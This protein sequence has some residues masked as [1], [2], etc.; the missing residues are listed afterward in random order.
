MRALRLVLITIVLSLLLAPVAQAAPVGCAQAAP[1]PD[2][3]QR[4]HGHHPR[5]GREPLVHRELGE[6]APPRSAASRRPA[7]SPSSRW[8]AT[9]A[10]SPTSS[11]GP[12]TSS[13]TR[14]TRTSSAGSPPTGTLAPGGP[15][16]GHGRARRQPR[17]ARRRRLDH[18]LQQQQ[19]LALRHPDR[20]VH[21]VR[22]ADARALA[23]RRRG[24]RVG[25]RVVHR[26]RG[27]QH[28]PARP[29]DR[30]HHRD[31][32][33]GSSRA[34]SRSR[35]TGRSGSPCASPRRASGG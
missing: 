29:G 28:R 21:A 31:P 26:G 19:R 13:T 8:S 33:D 7:P 34:A 15:D 23:V 12:A 2:R 14:P 4:P 25:H 10:S 3:Q 11:R 22:H 35:P 5:L 20:A 17:R 16:A 27:Q 18:R 30:C 24:G 1:D 6:P 32:D 9:S